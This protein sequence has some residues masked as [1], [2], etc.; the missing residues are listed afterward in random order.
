MDA[1]GEDEE[2]KEHELE[3]GK[4]SVGCDYDGRGGTRSEDGVEE[5]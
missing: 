4:R 1:V 2:H 5:V 3:S